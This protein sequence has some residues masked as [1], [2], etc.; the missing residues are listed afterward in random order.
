MFQKKLKDEDTFL[1]INEGFLSDKKRSLE[2]SMD[3]FVKN[4]IQLGLQEMQ[5]PIENDKLKTIKEEIL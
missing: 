3:F 2:V 4:L 5:I 1:A